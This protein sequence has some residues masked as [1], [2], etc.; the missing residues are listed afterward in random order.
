MN[1]ATNEREWSPFFPCNRHTIEFSITGLNKFDCLKDPIGI[2]GI[3]LNHFSMGFDSLLYQPLLRC[4]T[5]FNS[6]AWQSAENQRPGGLLNPN[7]V[8][9]P[10]TGQLCSQIERAGVM[11]TAW[12]SIILIRGMEKVNG[13]NGSYIVLCR[14]DGYFAPRIGMCTR[15][16]TTKSPSLK[17][18]DVATEFRLLPWRL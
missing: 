14:D 4:V 8:S 6:A 9:V 3:K 13:R 10:C 1:I 16:L 12:M 17:P 18:S 7:L 5:G 15:W 2:G 11:L